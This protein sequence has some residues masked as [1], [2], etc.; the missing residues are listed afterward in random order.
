MKKRQTI[1][2]MMMTLILCTAAVLVTHGRAVAGI[3]VGAS[4]ERTVDVAGSADG[5]L[6]RKGSVLFNTN[7]RERLC[8]GRKGPTVICRFGRVACPRSSANSATR[9]FN[10][11]VIAPPIKPESVST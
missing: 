1:L 6:A 9:Y 5:Y 4:P 11:R 2:V 7:C 3:T 10:F 8:E